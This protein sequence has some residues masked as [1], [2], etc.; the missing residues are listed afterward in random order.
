MCM[1]SEILVEGADALV[2]DAQDIGT[3][4]TFSK[5]SVVVATPPRI[6]KSARQRASHTYTFS[7]LLS[8]SSY[9][10]TTKSASH[11]AVISHL[12]D[13]KLGRRFRIHENKIVFRSHQQGSFRVGAVG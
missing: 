6:Q 12:S 8:S 11:A 9:S 2:D 3:P 13:G 4:P 10:F 7:S 1:W 5:S